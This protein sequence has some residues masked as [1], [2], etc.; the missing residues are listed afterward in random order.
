[1]AS[2]G[3]QRSKEVFQAALT[4]APELRGAFL[5]EACGDDGELRREVHRLL[6][7]H[8]AAGGFL[9]RPVE[10]DTGAAE[11]PGA[12]EAGPQRIGP[13]QILDTIAHGG[14]GIVYRAVRD[15]DTFRKTVALKLVRGG[16]HSEFF[17]RRFRQERQILARLQHPNIATVLTT[18]FP[19]AAP[20]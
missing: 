5:D 2:S 15:D 11:E 3:W 1:M 9:S 18:S 20:F 8:D 17:E 16:R 10:L 6:A 19:A 13:Y 7:A 4:R 14:M 12:L